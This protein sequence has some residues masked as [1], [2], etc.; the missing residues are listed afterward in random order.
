MISDKIEAF[1]GDKGYDS[2]AIREE[3]AKAEPDFAA[4][5]VASDAA[6]A[7]Q[8]AVRRQVRDQ[9]LNLYA[10]FSPAQKAVVRDAAAA[11]LAKMES[12]RARMKER[13]TKSQ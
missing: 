6:Q 10:T 12:F 11:K 1:L 13:M 8:Q 4:V 5:G 3:L 9:W 7:S 2:D